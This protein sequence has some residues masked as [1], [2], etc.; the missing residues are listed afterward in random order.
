MELHV[1]WI[2]QAKNAY[3]ILV[4]TPVEKR[5]VVKMEKCY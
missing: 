4:K 1:T 5:P 3:T 2:G